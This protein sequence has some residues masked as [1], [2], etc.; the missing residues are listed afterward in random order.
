[1]DK[2][3]IVKVGGNILNHPAVLSDFL[4]DFSA[5]DGLKLLVHGGGRKA[6][7][8]LKA[9]GIEP[10]MIN[11]RRVTDEQSLEVVTMVYAGLINKSLITQLQRRGCNAIG[12]CGA[13]LNIIQ[14]HKRVVKDIDYGFAGD[15][16]R[17]NGSSIQLF[18]K[19]QIIP[20]FCAISHDLNGQLLNTNADTIA[21]ELAIE[22]AKSYEVD[23][24]LCFEKPGVLIDLND[25]D[26]V[27]ID[28]NEAQ[29]L[30]YKEAGVI[31]E[32]MIPKMDNAFNALRE[33]V[34]KV[35][36]CDANALRA[37][38]F[39]GTNLVLS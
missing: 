21:A 8:V 14:A 39:P 1:M 37:N 30:A 17:I 4:D 13:D 10:V 2:L 22:L 18:F 29:Y 11:G 27:L 19:H 5:W 34:Q 7:E 9:M 28:L 35:R 20:V 3:R 26:S 16:D 23:L 6:S 25:P 38:S 31:F 32:G 33:G 12:L 15:I 36:V 24:Y